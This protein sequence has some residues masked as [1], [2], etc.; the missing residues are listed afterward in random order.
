MTVGEGVLGGVNVAVG[1]LVMVGVDDGVDVRVN[2]GVTE[3]VKVGVLVGVCVKVNVTE[4]GWKGVLVLVGVDVSVGVSEAASVKM[5]GVR[6]IVGVKM[7]NVSVAVTVMGVLDGVAA[8][9]FGSGANCTAIQP[10]Q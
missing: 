1:V 5:P 3:G 10:R 4:G 8:M 9:A 2:V 7:L 6:L